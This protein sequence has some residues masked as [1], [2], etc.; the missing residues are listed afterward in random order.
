MQI[1]IVV[2]LLG[3]FSMYLFLKFEILFIYYYIYRNRVSRINVGKVSRPCHYYIN[4][5]FLSACVTKQYMTPIRFSETMLLHLAL[6]RQTLNNAMPE[7][8]F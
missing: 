1:S 3:L 6:R 8:T 5:Y 4:K 2:E 7:T